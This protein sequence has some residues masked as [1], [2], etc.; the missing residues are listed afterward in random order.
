MIQYI[1]GLFSQA[2]WGRTPGRQAGG[3]YTQTISCMES[4]KMLAFLVD[5]LNSVYSGLVVV[6]LFIYRQMF[7]T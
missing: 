6:L 3:Y 2:I 4:C 7:P 5:L 1:V